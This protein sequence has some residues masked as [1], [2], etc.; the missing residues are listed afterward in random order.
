MRSPILL[1]PALGYSGTPFLVSQCAPLRHAPSHTSSVFPSGVGKEKLLKMT[2]PPATLLL[3]SSKMAPVVSV[4]KATHRQPLMLP[5]LI[6]S[7]L[8]HA[9]LILYFILSNSDFLGS[10]FICGFHFQA[11]LSFVHPPP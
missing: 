6:L 1:F 10:F 5:P 3:S 11:L 7:P 4:A 2:A 8:L 9:A